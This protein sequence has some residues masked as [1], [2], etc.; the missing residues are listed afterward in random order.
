[1]NWVELRDLPALDR[2]SRESLKNKVAAL[3]SK[4]SSLRGAN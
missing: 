3:H 2:R 4:S 1:M